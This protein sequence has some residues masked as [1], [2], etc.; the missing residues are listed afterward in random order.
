MVVD[1]P[2]RWN[3]TL[4]MLRNF[5]AL[6]VALRHFYA[7]G[8]FPLN[9]QELAAAKDIAEAQIHVEEAVKRLSLDE[10]TIR[11]AD[12]ALQVSI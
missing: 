1:V 2:I 3:S 10:A 5:L 12:L 7:G 9:R 11:S 6:E 4:R 8:T